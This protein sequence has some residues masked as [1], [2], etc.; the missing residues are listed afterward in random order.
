MNNMLHEQLNRLRL[1]SKLQEGQSLDTGNGLTVYEFSYTNW[2]WRKWNRDNKDEV[3][4]FLQ[5]FY[6]SI[7]QSVEQ[8]VGDIRLTKDEHKKNKLLHVASNLAEKL[9]SSISGVEK[10]SRTYATYPKTTSTLEG[11]V[12]D[13]AI[14]TYKQLLEVMPRDKLTKSLKDNVTYNG[15]ILYIG[16]ASNAGTEE[17][18]ADVDED[19]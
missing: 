14:V 3:T 6:R 12:Q 8:L 10:L 18:N 1:I 16:I 17:K 5:E 2:L 13:F 15:M 9:K 19:M 7:D 4:R 11:I